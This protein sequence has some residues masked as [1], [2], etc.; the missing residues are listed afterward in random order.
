MKT[1]NKRKK[2]SKTKKNKKNK[3]KGGTINPFSDFFGIFNTM[4]YNISNAFSTFTIKPPPAYLNPSD[5]SLN[6]SVAKQFLASK[7]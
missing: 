5:N 7:Q 6:P 3:M 4:S 1:Y 2:C